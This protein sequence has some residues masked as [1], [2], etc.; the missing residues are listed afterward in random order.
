MPIYQLGYQSVLLTGEI[1]MQ[2]GLP[3]RFYTLD[4]S[5]MFFLSR[6]TLS[7]YA[8]PKKS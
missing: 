5:V 3:I 6:S 1:L 7:K 4:D 2:A 8:S